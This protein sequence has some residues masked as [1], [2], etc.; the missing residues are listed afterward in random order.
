MASPRGEPFQL[1]LTALRERLRAGHLPSGERIAAAALADELRLSPTPVREAL[2][3]LAGEGLIEDRR[4]QGYFI[5]TL[6]PLDVADLYRLSFAHLALA[7]EVRREGAGAGGGEGVADSGEDPVCAV[8]QQL[9][10]WVSNA[11]GRLLA[12]S[13]VKL[14]VQ[15]GAVRRRE[16]LLFG[17][18]AEEAAALLASVR[19]PEDGGPLPALRRYH[20]RRIAAAGR[21]ASLLERGV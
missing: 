6:S 20:N 4:G 12:A 5:R 2:S 11:G 3:R 21:L 15:L 16:P 8:E 9:L 17:D 10:S 7:L 19:R 1:A 18:L 13:Y 14:T